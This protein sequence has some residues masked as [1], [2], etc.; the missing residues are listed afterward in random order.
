[1]VVQLHQEILVLVVE[2]PLMEE[3]QVQQVQ[4]LLG[5]REV[6]QPIQVEVV[7][8]EEMMGVLLQMVP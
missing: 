7:V 2:E 4:G 1:M 6:Q 5:V 8:M 3:M